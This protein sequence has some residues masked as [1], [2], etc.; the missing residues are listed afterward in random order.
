MLQG[1]HI[2]SFSFI[3]K[4]KIQNINLTEGLLYVRMY[5]WKQLLYKYVISF[6]SVRAVRF[7]KI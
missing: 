7:F 3:N 2:L 4:D 5:D 6:M 1:C